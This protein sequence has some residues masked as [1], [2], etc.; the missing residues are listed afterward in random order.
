MVMMFVEKSGRLGRM[1]DSLPLVAASKLD[2]NTVLVQA[3][4]ASLDLSG[5]I[6]AVGRVKVDSTGL[7]LDLK[8]SLFKCG[9]V[10]TN[11]LCAVTVLDEEARVTAQ[12]DQVV[13]LSLD[14][15]TFGDSERLLSG[16]LLENDA[17]VQRDDVEDESRPNTKQR[18]RVKSKPKAKSKPKPKVKR[19]HGK[20]S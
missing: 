17:D 18:G 8:G 3:C 15:E 7:S 9:I 1:K 4:T 20:K 13:N 6:G 10:D 5:D 14:T 19:S 2:D 11:C 12:F 16:M